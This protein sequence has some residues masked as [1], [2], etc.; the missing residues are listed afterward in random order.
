ML[1]SVLMRPRRTLGTEPKAFNLLVE[2]PYV[3]S[4]VWKLAI[5]A[6]SN[7]E[8]PIVKARVEIDVQVSFACEDTAIIFTRN[9]KTVRNNFDFSASNS[10]TNTAAY[11][12][13]L[14]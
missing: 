12:T 4:N 14:A 11:I 5:T 8:R 3:E 6:Q 9:L 7:S 2:K 13:N 10:G 1:G